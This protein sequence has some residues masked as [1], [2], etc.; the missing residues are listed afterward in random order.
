MP[1]ETS[2]IAIIAV[3]LGLAFLGGFIASRRRLPPLVGYLLAGVTIGPFTPGFVA[4]GE[5]AAQ[6]AEIGVILLMFGV[7]IHFSFK[8]LLDVRRIALPGAVV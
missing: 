4:D 2:L 8:D 1:H 5:L 3:G 6:L 7:G